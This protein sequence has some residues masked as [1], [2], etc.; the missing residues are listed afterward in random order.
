MD[1]NNLIV[2]SDTHVC[3]RAG[4]CIPEPFHL[5][6]GGTYEASD[7]QKS[8]WA[9]WRKFW[10]EWVPAVTKG[11]PYAVLVNGDLMDGVHHGSKTQISQNLADQENLAIQIF[12]P[13]VEKC[14]GQFYVVR[15]TEAHSGKSGEEEER[16]AKSLGAIPDEKGQ[17]SR[18]EIFKRVGGGLVHAL[19]HI[20]TTGTS[21]Y[22]STAVMKE[23]VESFTESG[24]WGDTPP[25]VVVRSH[26]HRHLEVRIPTKSGYGIS[27][28]TAG[29]Q[30]K[31]PFTYKIPGGRLTTPQIG[32][33]LIRQGD[34]DLHTRHKVWRLDR[35]A[36]V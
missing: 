4:L 29:W 28:V 5:D 9:C 20:G 8:L 35:P 31:T 7:A 13:I 36:V 24:R 11:E 30:L 6:E 18:F 19:H 32:G 17:H 10:G 26:R 3:C 21:S 16:L 12:E 22:E 14:A 27:F 1:I 34:A 25:D 2:I 23:L 15:G 33:S